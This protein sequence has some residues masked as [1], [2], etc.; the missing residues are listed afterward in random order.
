MATEESFDTK[1]RNLTKIYKKILAE[2]QE[3][4]PKTGKGKFNLTVP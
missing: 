2:K 1:E 3:N 4:V